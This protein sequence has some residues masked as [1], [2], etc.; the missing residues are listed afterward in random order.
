[1]RAG[2]QNSKILVRGAV[3]FFDMLKLNSRGI[4]KEAHI[5]FRDLIVAP[6]LMLHQLQ[7]GQSHR[8]VELRHAGIQTEQ[9]WIVAT[10]VPVVPT[11][12]NHPCQ[13]RVVRANQTAFTCDQ[14]FRRGQREN[15][16]IPK[17]TDRR[18]S[19]TASER[20]G[21]IENELEPMSGRNLLEFVDGGRVAVEMYGHNDACTFCDPCPQIARINPP[22]SR[23]TVRKHWF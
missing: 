7:A 13:C 5:L 22:G 12:S 19:I 1:M 16:G 18:P 11:C 14:Q 15:L 10:R 23:I 17:G 2:N 8:S 4:T 20:V 21:S 9:L 3:T 6:N